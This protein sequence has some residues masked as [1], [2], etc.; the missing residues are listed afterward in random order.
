[1]V[2]QLAERPPQTALLA[3]DSTIFLAAFEEAEPIGFVL[4]YELSRRHGDASMVLV[5]EVDV[6]AAHRRRGVATALLDELAR[7]ARRR[8]IAEGFVL[9]DLD[10]D[11]ANALYGSQGG[12][13]RT[14]VEWDFR[15]D[16]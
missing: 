7:I 11:A 16:P 12:E 9:T 14:V 1:M 5:Y 3:E 2:A 8:G 15:Y 4:A 13:R 10:N 6:E